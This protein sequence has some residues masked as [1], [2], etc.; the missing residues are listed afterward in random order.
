[1]IGQCGR[2]AIISVPGNR[3]VLWPLPLINPKSNTHGL[4]LQAR[5]SKADYTI[6]HEI[7]RHAIHVSETLQ[8]VARSCKALLDQQNGFVRH[9]DVDSSVTWDPVSDRLQLNL[10]ATEN[11]LARSEANCARIQNEVALVSIKSVKSI[12]KTTG[13]NDRF[14][15]RLFIWRHKTT[16][17]RSS[18]CLSTSR[19]RLWQ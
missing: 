13:I 3:F 6:I 11:L 7:A 18:K 16:V 5:Q 17:G 4:A 15:L 1:M 19:K 14:L 2:S 10:Q 12:L 9:L 8:V